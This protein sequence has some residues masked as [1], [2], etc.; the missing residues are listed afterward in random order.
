MIEKVTLDNALGVVL[1]QLDTAV[2]GAYV[3]GENISGKQLKIQQTVSVNLDK[4]SELD[5]GISRGVLFVHYSS[6]G[7][8][9]IF[10]TD[11]FETRLVNGSNEIFRTSDQGSGVCVYKEGVGSTIKI[12]QYMIDLASIVFKCL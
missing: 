4:G 12:K 5:T 2:D 1:N 11:S 8:A 3:Y 10:I 7:T 6:G 9:A